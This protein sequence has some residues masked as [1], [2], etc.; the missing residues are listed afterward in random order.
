LLKSVLN[1]CLGKI[2]IPFFLLFPFADALAQV[3]ADFSAINTDGCGPLIIQFNNLSTGSG[4]LTYSW[5]LGNGNTS[6]AQNPSA[7]YITPGVYTVTLTVTNGTDT[8]TE[9][10]TNYIEVFAPPVPNFTA[11]DTQGCFPFPVDFTDLSTPGSSPVTSWV[12]DFGDGTISNDTN[13]S[14]I[15]P[16][17]GSYNV[18]LLLTDAN[19]C[20]TQLTFNNYITVT[21][22]FPTVSFTADPLFS[23]NVPETVVFTNTSSGS[24]ALNYQWDFGDGG[25][26]T[27]TDPSHS[28]TAAGTYSVTLTATDPVG[29][30]ASATQSNYITVVDSVVAD[31]SASTTNACVNQAVQFSDQSNPAPASWLWNFGDGNTSTIQ[32]PSHTY[33]TPGTY[34]VRLIISYNGNCSDTLLLTNYITVSDVPVVNFAADDAIGCQIPFT[35]N[36]TDNTTGTGPFTY[37]WSFGDGSFSTLQNPQHTYTSFGNYTVSLTVTNPFGCSVINTQNQYIQISETAAGFSPDIYG[38]C[39]PLTVNFTDESI[40]GSNITS[41]HWDFDDGSTS[42]LQNPQH[43]YTDTGIY[44]ITLIIQNANGCIDTLVRPNLIFAYTPPGANFTGTPNFVCPGDE[45]YFTDLSTEAT[46]WSW[47]FGDGTFST[48]QNPIHTYGDTGYHTVTLIALNNG[49]TDTITFVNYVYVRPAVAE[50]EAVLNCDTPYTVFFQNNSVA[51]DSYTWNFGDGSPISNTF[52]PSHTYAL[53][54]YYEVLLTVTSDT[55]GCIH[56]ENENFTITDPVAD[57]V[58][59]NTTGCGPLTVTFAESSTDAVSW[60]WNFGDGTFTFDQNP[61]HTYTAQGTYDV[62]LVITDLNGCKD[63]LIMPDYVIA[64]GSVPNFDIAFT[65]GCDTLAVTFTDLSTPSG[66]V[67]TW[68]W[69]FGDGGTSTQQ[70]PTHIY[71]DAGTYDV[72]LTITDNAGCTN[73]IVKYNFVNYIP[74]PTPNFVASGVHLCPYELVSFSNLSSPDGVNL[75]WDFGDGTTST[76]SFPFH[77]YADPGVYTVSLT[78]SN[79][80]G[81]DSTKIR[82]NYITVEEPTADF[83]AFPTVAF[84]PP[85][86]VNFTDHSLGNIVSW[87]WDFGDGSSST[88]QNPAHIYTVPGI[89]DVT[90]IIQNSFG[91]V[92]TVEIPGIINLSGPTGTFSFAPDSAGCLPFTISFNASSSNATSFTWDF[93]DGSVENGD[94][95]IVHIYNQLGSFFPNLILQDANGCSFVIPGSGN[96]IVEPLAVDAGNDIIICREDSTQL[97]ATGGTTYA[98]GPTAGLSNPNIAN[99]MASPDVTTKYYVTVTLGDC[100]N[101]DSVTVTVASTATADFS[102]STVCNGDSTLFTDL[103][104]NGGDSLVVWDWSFGDGG[105]SSLQNPA[106]L[107]PAGGTYTVNLYVATF[108]GCD[109][110]FSTDVV[111]NSV[112]VAAFSVPNVCL[113]DSSIFTD[114]SSIATGNIVSWNWDMDDGTI[115]FT[116][117]PQYLYAADTTYHV[118]LTVTGT[119]GCTDSISHAVIIYPLPVAG[120]SVED[121]CVTQ[122]SFFNDTSAISSGNVSNWQWFFGNGN[123]SGQQNPTQIYLNPGTYNITLISTSGFGCSDTT[124]GTTTVFPNPVSS[125]SANSDSSCIFPVSVGFT[126][127]STGATIYD[128]SFGNGDSSTAFSPTVIYDTSGAWSVTLVVENQFGCTDTSTAIY[129]V[130]PIPHADFTI[131]DAEGCQPL[132]IEFNS[133]ISENAVL[134]EWNFNDGNTSTEQNPVNVFQLPGMYGVTLVVTGLGGCMDTVSY[135][136]IITVFQNPTAGFTFHVVN[137]PNIDGT[138][139]FTNLSTPIVSSLWDFGD[140]GSSVNMNPTHQYGNYGAYPVMLIVTDSLGCIDTVLN[141]IFVDFFKGL[142][143]PNAFIPGADGGYNIF[144]PKGTGLLSYTM[145]IFDTWGNLLFETSKLENGQPAEGWNGIYNG[146]LLPQNAY[147]W[148]I[149][150]RFGDGSIW[151]GQTYENGKQRIVGSVTLM[152]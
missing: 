92:D 8:D 44:T 79:A 11:S 48:E 63:T 50:F 67:L 18:T 73:T 133:G 22:S 80:N 124:S 90:L 110:T 101:V 41:W 68:N 136:N 103:S 45:V 152:R 94:T 100:S 12:W 25:N 91:C 56:S 131:S 28:Y 54:G 77:A 135:P 132:S 58:G 57:F 42:T 15:Y 129:N 151:E 102:F 143:V 121:V 20:F 141:N 10:K 140:G 65:A 118:T 34:T 36:F 71:Q 145:Q 26:S 117:N 40:S 30:S 70:N 39:L 150:A 93:G 109:D 114:Q 59:V 16:N 116:Q 4:T 33:T 99:P 62:T 88:L 125:F 61:S 5:N 51:A 85:L 115:F 60:Y 2:I 3:N 52:E 69:D 126:N 127:T 142:Y 105:T 53:P 113:N 43:T 128:W 31:F 35:V 138:T 123:T 112:P 149:T 38:F 13:P 75:F 55:T 120:F 139:N 84:C 89:F 64:T 137:D 74:Y 21:G 1:A 46:D 144:L 119:G 29:C 9:T 98:W 147:V 66:S 17:A 72:S 83:S 122:T 27:A 95:S 96:I 86:L 106:H 81:C 78:V 19:G 14:H 87:H 82:L 32:N 104:L 107:Y 37:S 134:Y 49:C 130:Y 23:C 76:D 148:Q 111:V 24:G 7:T 108:N 97:V 47:D 6:T 146:E